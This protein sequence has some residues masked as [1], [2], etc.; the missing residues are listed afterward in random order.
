MIGELHNSTIAKHHAN[1]TSY[2]QAVELCVRNEDEI[3]DF[4]LMNVKQKD[5]ELKLSLV[6]CL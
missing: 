6:F 4:M 5:D 3:K 1:K 2:L